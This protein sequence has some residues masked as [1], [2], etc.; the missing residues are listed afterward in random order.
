MEAEKNFLNEILPKLSESFAN[1]KWVF[2]HENVKPRRITKKDIASFAR[3][4]EKRKKIFVDIFSGVE[5]GQVLLRNNS[6]S[7]WEWAVCQPTTLKKLKSLSPQFKEKH[8]AFKWLDNY[9][10]NE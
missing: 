3:N 4:R 2:I 1:Y 5:D 10:Y 9:L 6:G 8:D 7:S